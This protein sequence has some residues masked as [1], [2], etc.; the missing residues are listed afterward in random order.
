MTSIHERL[1]D[2]AEAGDAA[3]CSL[4]L[5]QGADPRASCDAALCSAA[6]AGR[7]ECVRLLIP[8]SYTS[9]T[10]EALYFSAANGHAECVEL[11]IPV[12][13]P[14]T[15]YSRALLISAQR[16]L[17]ECV[18]LLL[19]VSDSLSRRSHL[20]D[21]ERRNNVPL[22]AAFDRGRARVVSAML[23]HEP[24]LLKSLN[25]PALLADSISQGHADLSALLASII[26]QQE[27]SASLPTPGP[28]S[29]TS[30]L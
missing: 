11:L 23:A 2:A 7:V 29:P 5:S 26:E 19:P 30:R 3:L 6:A 14:K 9:A 18:R 16:G 15:K 1:I 27:L 21:L 24:R 22:Y 28:S 25:L 12:S 8:L 10:S 4:L 20:P 13:D 17:L